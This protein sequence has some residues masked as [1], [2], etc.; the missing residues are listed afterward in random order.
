LEIFMTELSQVTARRN[1]SGH[2]TGSQPFH[3]SEEL[4]Q[5]LEHAH[6]LS[7]AFR[8]WSR[9]N[10]VAHRDWLTQLIDN[11]LV[12]RPAGSRR[13]LDARARRIAELWAVRDAVDIYLWKFDVKRS[14]Q[15]T[16]AD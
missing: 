4:R 5:V 11:L 13:T 9:S 6:R 8:Y 2:N 12:M 1:G 16:S 14:Q 10:L 3:D 15:V 7:P